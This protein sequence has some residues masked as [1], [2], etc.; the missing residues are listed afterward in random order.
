MNRIPYLDGIRGIAIIMVFFAHASY[1]IPVVYQLGIFKKILMNSHL[2]VMLFFVL[3]GYLITTL[4]LNEKEKTG[5]ISIKNFYI[6]RALRIFPVFYLYLLIVTILYW[7]GKIKIPGMILVFSALY[8]TNYMN[9]FLTPTGIA[10]PDYKIIGHFWTLSL[11]EQFYLI[12]PSALILAGIA[13]MKQ[14][15]PYVLLAYPVMRVLTYFL[16]P[17]MRGQIGMMLHTMGDCIFWGCYAAL[18]QRFHP[19]KVARLVAL[20]DTKKYLPVLLL[21]TLFVVCPIFSTYLKGAFDITV[22]FSIEGTIIAVMLVYVL[23]AKPA[24]CNFLNNKTLMYIGVLS[25]SLY[26]WHILFLRTS[27]IL[28]TFPLNVLASFAAAYISFTCI[29]MPILKLKSRFK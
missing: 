9:L 25:Y 8:L 4:L 23:A 15:L 5:T 20:F 2:G 26:V 6:R 24:W 3:S 22:G 29:E 1:S 27:T 13:R 16:F 10:C 18:V 11:E 21:L 14:L 7:L 12:W 17:S 28:S 19:D